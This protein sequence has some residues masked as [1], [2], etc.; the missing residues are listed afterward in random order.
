MKTLAIIPARGGSKSIPDKNII[1]VGGKPLLA[2]TILAAQ[3]SSNIDRLVV[4]TDDPKIAEVAEEYGAEVPFL[5][6]TELAQ[7]DTP[8]I[9]PI[10]HAV[11]WLSANQNYKSDYVLNL[12]PTSPLRTGA[13]IDAAL[14]LA[15]EKIAD[16]VVSVIQPKHHPYWTQSIN[17]EG[18]MVDFFSQGTNITR[19][20]DLPPAY[21]LNGA[22]YLVETQVLLSLQ[23]WYT[24][25]TYAYLMPPER[26]LDIDTPWDL[27]LVDLILRNK[28]EYECN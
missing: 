16:G 27:Y 26:S 1:E 25:K 17:S 22:I 28:V 23:T 15:T 2:W 10:I 7:D 14:M 6:P 11:N 8:G 19:R 13:D 24:D 3:N 9:T 4:T 5:R 18:R 21:A 12:Q 20:Q